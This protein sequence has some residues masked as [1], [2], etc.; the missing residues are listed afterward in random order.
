MK[1]LLGF[2][3]SLHIIGSLDLRSSEKCKPYF[4]FD[5]VDHFKFTKSLSEY[6]KIENNGTRQGKKL[7]KIL[8]GE[9]NIAFSDTLFPKEAELLGFKRQELAEAEF[10][11]IN[12]VF[13][14]KG[15]SNETTFCDPMYNDILIFKKGQK[16][17]GY[18]KI[19]FGCDKI[20]IIGKE[21]GISKLMGEDHK[22]LAHLLN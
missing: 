9:H 19:C 7:S 22:I 14:A 13:C 8:F 1:I 15:Y 3:V 5:Q 11:N 21:V 16:I 6:R 17:I 4:E 20:S 2:L 10:E 12:S 18:S